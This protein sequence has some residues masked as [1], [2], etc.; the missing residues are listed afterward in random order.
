MA[1]V[2]KKEQYQICVEGF[3]EDRCQGR[4]TA[5]DLTLN[6]HVQGGTI[7][8]PG[9]PGNVMPCALNVTKA[10]L[11]IEALEMFIDIESPKAASEDVPF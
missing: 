2:V 4:A 5:E 3:F 11:L 1:N 10:K 7:H 8:S 9:G 6:L